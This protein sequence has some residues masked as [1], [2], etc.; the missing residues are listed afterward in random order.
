MLHSK[1]KNIFLTGLLVSLLIIT[2]SFSRQSL[3]N[4]HKQDDPLI[5]KE[6]NKIVAVSKLSIDKGIEELEKLTDLP[7]SLNYKKNYVLAR[8]YER[9][10]DPTKA[11]QIYEKI[12][13]YN[14]PLRERVILHYARLNA[15]TGNDQRALKYINK[16]LHDFP[17]SR[18]VPQ[19]KYLLAQ[20]QFRLHHTHQ[21]INTLLSIRSEFPESQ[22]GIATNY[23]LGEYAFGKENYKEA[24]KFWREYLVQSPDGRFA[25]EITDVL[26]HDKN[27]Q[28]VKSDYV[29]LGDVF[30]EKKDYKK[31]AVYYKIADIKKKYY[32]LGYSLY[33]INN[34]KEA[35]YYLSQYAKS[36][37]SSKNSKLALY[38]A[39]LCTPSFLRESFWKQ[40]TK[41][42]PELAY[43]AIYKKALL[44]NS[45]YRKE[46]LLS[47]YVKD[48][49]QSIFAP[50]AAWE[51]MWLKIQGNDLNEA[52]KTGDKYFQSLSNK[53]NSFQE[54]LVK[55]CFWLGKIAEKAGNKERAI[56][57]YKKAK[58]TIFDNYYSF[59]SEARFLHL[60][61][62][63]TDFLGRRNTNSHPEDIFWTIPSVIKPDAIKKHFGET[64]LELVQL[65]QYDEAVELIGKSKYHQKQVLA[66]L[67]A[68]N[69]E[70]DESVNIASELTYEYNYKSSSNIW[71]LAY[72]LYFWHQIFET[73]KNYPDVDPLF[74]LGLIRQESRFETSA[75]SVSNARGLMQL[76]PQTAKFVAR[77]L[78]VNLS[79]V[80]LLY[81][82]ELNIKLGIKYLDDLSKD[83]N[84]L[85][86]VVS[87][88][89]AGPHAT[90]RWLKA[91]TNSVWGSNDLDYFVEKIP[92]SQTKDYVKKVFANYWTYLKL[93]SNDE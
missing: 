32:S 23:Y 67:K 83:Y 27:L 63:H 65:Q 58:D 90:R 36:Y 62:N 29:L 12:I 68:L 5:E 73:C 22:F 9:K 91:N 59:R 48:F 56:Y 82:P 64:V 6:L 38:Y 70:Y 78:N 80:D 55:I 4:N 1:F 30:F 66:W 49:P 20:T 41:D 21:A 39:S 19:A 25:R 3:N 74:V 17:L 8:L 51:I 57:Y 11:M 50:D 10:D 14:H 75:I 35:V 46:K 40:V 44:E 72:P 93:Y 45:S 33:R 53:E 92:Y 34:K 81:V 85:L 52:S 86:Y 61:Q 89:N 2:F 7:S 79:S 60:T 42:I 16:L 13:S 47:D 87:S 84:N 54:S 37:P 26:E 69:N 28:L 43:Y 88:Y 15:E 77:Q 76:I 71:E 24:L 31:A 18:S